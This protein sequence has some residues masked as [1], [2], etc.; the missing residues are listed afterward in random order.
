M[1]ED[2]DGSGYGCDNGDNYDELGEVGLSN[3]M[4]G[5]KGMDVE[6]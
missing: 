3:L 6:G 5:G 4:D 2:N 1:R